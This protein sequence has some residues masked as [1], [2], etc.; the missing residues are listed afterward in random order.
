M[1]VTAWLDIRGLCGLGLRASWWSP[2]ML[3]HC[4]RAWEGACISFEG[5]SLDPITSETN[6]QPA[7]G[8]FQSQI[9][10]NYF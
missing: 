7:C 6:F 8:G 10:I 1:E 9:Q 4:V 3:G 2:D 5:Q